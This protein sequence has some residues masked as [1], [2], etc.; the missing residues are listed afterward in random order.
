M[1]T[2]GGGGSSGGAVASVNGQ[3]G[4]VVLDASD[5]GAGPSPIRTTYAAR[6]AAGVAGRVWFSTEAPLKAFDDGSAWHLYAFGFPVTDPTLPTWSWDNQETAVVDASKGFLHL[7]DVAGA[8]TENRIRKFT[9]PATPWTVTML[10]VIEN[11]GL[12]NFAHAGLVLRESGTGKLRHLGISNEH[13]GQVVVY[14]SVSSTSTYTL[15]TARNIFPDPPGFPLWLQVT[16]DGTNLIYRYSFDGEHF[17]FVRTETKGTF[18]TV[19]PDQIGFSIFAEPL[20][21]DLNPQI[22]VYSVKVT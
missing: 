3:T 21:A 18:F 8:T 10:A 5:V 7:S 20:A 16:A 2:S 11:L 4:V 13:V 22:S 12:A 1:P 14:G 19:E 15:A 6:P 9:A 17:N